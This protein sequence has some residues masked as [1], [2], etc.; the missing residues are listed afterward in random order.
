[1]KKAMELTLQT[2]IVGVILL[3]VLA[4]V[5]FIF[6]R[7]MDGQG[8]IVEGNTEDLSNCF[9]Q[10][11]DCTFLD[12]FRSIIFPVFIVLKKIWIKKD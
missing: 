4:V 2:V 8:Q 1:M 7:G 3:V 10:D 12:N 6:F 9:D 11:E 5:L